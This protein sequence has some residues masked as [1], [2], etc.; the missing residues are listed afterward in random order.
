MVAALGYLY[1][2]V[3]VLRCPD[4]AWETCVAFRLQVDDSPEP[5]KELRRLVE[6]AAAQ[7]NSMPALAW[8]PGP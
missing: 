6:K 5:I 4:A 2:F 3:F 1:V 7:R 8:V